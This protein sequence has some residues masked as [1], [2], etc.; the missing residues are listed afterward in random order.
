ML[1]V[2]LGRVPH[3]LLFEQLLHRQNVWGHVTILVPRA[4]DGPNNL[5]STWVNVAYECVV[6]HLVD[7]FQGNGSLQRSQEFDGLTSGQQLN[8]NHL[9]KNWT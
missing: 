7:L 2:R 1:H 8:G 6:P 4:N 9:G 5:E 3:L